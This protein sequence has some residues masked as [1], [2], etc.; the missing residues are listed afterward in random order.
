MNQG[1]FKVSVC[2]T[3]LAGA[4]EAS[5][6]LTQE[7]AGSNPF[8]VM[9]TIFV[10]EFSKFKETFRE[11]SIDLQNKITWHKIKTQTFD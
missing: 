6:S 9:A 1:Q 11:S 4:V 3:C 2:H 8:T 10:T 5:L 7:V